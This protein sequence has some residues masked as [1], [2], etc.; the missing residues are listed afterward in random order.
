[1]VT[2]WLRASVFILLP[3]AL[4]TH[5]EHAAAQIGPG[6]YRVYIHRDSG[7]SSGQMT[8]SAVG[9][10]LTEPTKAVGYIH[11]PDRDAQQ[12]VY[13]EEWFFYPDYIEEAFRRG[14][15]LEIVP[16]QA[17]PQAA[18]ATAP[19][20]GQRILATAVEYDTSD[21][22]QADALPVSNL[23]DQTAAECFITEV[24]QRPSFVRPGGLDQPVRV[25]IIRDL[26]SPDGSD[27]EQEW[28]LSQSYAFPSPL[29]GVITQLRLTPTRCTS[30]GELVDFRVTR[31]IHVRLSAGQRAEEVGPVIADEPHQANSERPHLECQFW[32]Y[33]SADA[34][35]WRY[36]LGLSLTAACLGVRRRRRSRTR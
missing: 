14:T 17:S 22:E 35:T 10:L 12:S 24:W 3:A 5:A 31:R 29:N 34:S 1:M 28:L 15:I 19:A 21:E 26:R 13:D 6:H 16:L 33:P 4:M 23:G 11:V 36:A 7:I 2:K 8:E 18:L 25:G 9:K 32:Y 20:D 30:G 27:A